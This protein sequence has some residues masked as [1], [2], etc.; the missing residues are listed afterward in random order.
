MALD[1]TKSPAELAAEVKATFD[2]ALNN[3]REIAE[4]AKSTASKGKSLSAETAEKAD[5]LLLSLGETKARLDELEQKTAR[6][7]SPEQDTPKSLG[8]RFTSAEGFSDFAEKGR[9]NDKF[10]V[11]VKADIMAGGTGA[12][13]MA[14]AVHSRHL[15]G[16][17]PLLHERLTIRNLLMPG[18]TDTPNIDYDVET[19]FTNNAGGVPEG[20]LPGQSSFDIEERQIRTKTLA[21]TMRVSKHAL[22]DV[23]QMES[24]INERLLLG[25]AQKEEAQLLYGDNTGENY[26]GIVP[27]ASAFQRVLPE[28]TGETSLDLVRLMIL[29][30]TLA[31]FPATGIV[32]N[33]IDWTW[34]EKLKDGNGRYIIGDPQGTTGKTLWNLPVVETTAMAVD[35]I[36]VGAFSM[37][38]QLFDQWDSHIETGYVNEDF[39]R[40]KVTLR[41]DM[42][43]AL[44]VYRPETFIYGDFGRQA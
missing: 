36:L 25:L 11:D 24:L 23:A 34:I 10:I 30:A 29:Q 43:G 37:G 41:A 14:A 44:A 42:R 16:I 12:G 35:K 4:E 5:E 7:G 13:S 28:E 19:G 2:K 6:A 27:Q 9:G 21:H 32:M 38:A 18:R 1:E 3:V 17:Q 20:G 8:E 22:S 15:P 39:A 33:P 40:G 26:H 31:H